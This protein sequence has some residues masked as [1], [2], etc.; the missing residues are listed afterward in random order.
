[1]L[2]IS[3]VKVQFLGTGIYEK[4]KRDGGERKGREREREKE[5]RK[6]KERE[7]NYRQLKV[8]HRNC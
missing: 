7:H 5:E 8:H 6:K 3:R 4:D 2:K 1:L